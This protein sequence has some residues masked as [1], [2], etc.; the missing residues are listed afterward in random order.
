MADPVADPPTEDALIPVGVVARPH[1]V[2]GELRVH[3]LNPGSTLLYEVGEI[4]LR[5]ADGVRLV[6]IESARRGPKGSVLMVLSTVA[7]REAADAL[8]GTELCVPRTALPETDDDEWYF[9][10]LIGL[11]A[12]TEAGEALGR[13]VD[14]IQYPTINCLV[15]LDAGDAGMVREVPMADPYLI[16]VDV[17][18]GTLTL[19]PIAEIPDRKPR[20]HERGA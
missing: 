19:S 1:G 8:R 11:A 14:V 10:D 2:R 7:G 12:Q 4:L 16:S 17:S 3:C 9:V 13:V 15:V 18:G 5:G 6:E 20:K